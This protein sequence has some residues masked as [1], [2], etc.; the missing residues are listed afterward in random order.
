MIV[1]QQWQRYTLQTGCDTGHENLQMKYATRVVFVLRTTLKLLPHVTKLEKGL[2][3][4]PN[5]PE[6]AFT[7]VIVTWLHAARKDKLGSNF[8]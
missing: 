8:S 7:I 3:T 2:H 5:E 6:S 1:I 4:T